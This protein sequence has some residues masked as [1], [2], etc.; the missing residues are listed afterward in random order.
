MDVV[1]DLLNPSQPESRLLPALIVTSVFGLFGY[2][3]RGVTWTGAIAGFVASF[4]LF[5]GLGLGGFVTLSAVFAI[6]WL[7]TRVGYARKRKLGVAESKSGRNARQVLAN[8]ATAATFAVLSLKFGLP[9]A[10]VAIAA[11]AEAAADTTSSEIG[12]ALSS[13]AWLITGFRSVPPGTNGAISLAGTVAGLSAAT[14]VTLI[15]L[16]VGVTDGLWI[17]VIAAFLGTLVDS[18]LGATLERAGRIGND[19]VNFI[20]TLAAAGFAL[21]LQAT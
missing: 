9:C 15:A 7:A 21:V 5:V 8:V 3:S 6:T 12:E 17:V 2:L 1:L 13:R 14:L 4:L 10:V 11:L 20:S 18:L 19:G 16:W